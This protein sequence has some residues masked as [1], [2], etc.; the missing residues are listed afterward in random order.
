MHMYMY[1]YQFQH[2]RYYAWELEKEKK[3]L[4][5]TLQYLERKKK[6]KHFE[7]EKKKLAMEWQMTHTDLLES[8]LQL[9]MYIVCNLPFKSWNSYTKWN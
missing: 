6:D 7:E 1:M 3:K 8:F 2:D 4:C 5:Q 9:Y